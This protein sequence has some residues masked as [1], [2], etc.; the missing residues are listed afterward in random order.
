MREN[1]T[2]F[3][4]A[5]KSSS[6]F[7]WHFCKKPVGIGIAKQ[8]F[9]TGVDSACDLRSSTNRHPTNEKPKKPY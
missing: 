5:Q 7:P 8:V 2:H 4:A 9:R 1:S 6:G 3:A